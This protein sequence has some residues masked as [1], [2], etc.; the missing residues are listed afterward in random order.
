MDARYKKERTKKNVTERNVK[1]GSLL[2]QHSETK[3][4]L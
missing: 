4:S 3:T 2:Q 1:E